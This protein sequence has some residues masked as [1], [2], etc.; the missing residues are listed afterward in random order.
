MDFNR[1][2]LFV[3]LMLFQISVNA[4]GKSWFSTGEGFCL[5]LKS[6]KQLSIDKLE[7]EL[8]VIG[9]YASPCLIQQLDSQETVDI[10]NERFSVTLPLSVLSNYFLVKIKSQIENAGNDSSLKQEDLFEGRVCCSKCALNKKG[11]VEYFGELVEEKINF[12][13]ETGVNNERFEDYKAL[14]EINR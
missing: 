7:K 14:F 12:E 4:G 3:V 6:N 13:I 2:C 5:N 9:L 11:F 8:E 1:S 10:Y